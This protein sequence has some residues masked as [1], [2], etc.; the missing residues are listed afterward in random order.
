[1]P[2]DRRTY[3]CD[4]DRPVDHI[5]CEDIDRDA[6]AKVPEELRYLEAFIDLEPFG[7]E[8]VDPGRLEQASDRPIEGFVPDWENVRA[9]PDSALRQDGF[10]PRVL[11]RGEEVDPA[12]VLGTD[13]RRVFTS[14]AYPWRCACRIVTSVGRA[15]GVLVGPRHVLTAS[16]VVNWAVPGGVNGVVEVGRQGGAVAGVSRIRRVFAFHRVTGSVDWLELDE[17]YAVLELDLPLGD[18]F[19]WIGAR[20]Y[21]SGWDRDPYWTNMGYP[22]DIGGGMW[23]TRQT[24]KWLDEHA[25]DF[26]SGR[27]MDTNADINPGNSGGP[28]FSYWSNGGWYAVA[29]VSAHSR[30]R[31]ENYCSGGRDLPRLVRVARGL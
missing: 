6:T 21:R 24:G 17:D 2:A 31:Q 23:P 28:M 11:M 9:K 19:G 22:G 13:E 1:M 25:W 20:T 7:V 4:P 3:D 5:R 18:R 27:A 16:H 12:V 30:R 29:V 8:V 15:S 26:G 14:S 10:S